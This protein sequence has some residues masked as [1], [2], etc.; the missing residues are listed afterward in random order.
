MKKPQSSVRYSVIAPGAMS[1]RSRPEREA[2]RRRR[3]ASPQSSAPPRVHQSR[4]ALA[5]PRRLVARVGVPIVHVAAT[6][7]LEVRARGRDASRARGT[8]PSPSPCCRSCNCTRRRR[9]VTEPISGHVWI[10]RCDSAR[11]T[12]PVTPCGSNWWKRSP[13]IVRPASLD[14]VEAE[15]RAARRRR[16]SAACRLGS[17]TTR[18][19]DGFRPSVVSPKGKA[20]PRPVR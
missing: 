6:D 20:P 8:A 11:I 16:S 14:G 1:T 19:A 5:T 15:R 2:R 13:T 10:A 18:P 17:R 7:R 12:V 9:R 4:S 3:R